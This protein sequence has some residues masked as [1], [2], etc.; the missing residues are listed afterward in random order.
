MKTQE[1]I[2]EFIVAYLHQVAGEEQTA[3]SLEWLKNPDNREIYMQME[4]IIRLSGEVRLLDNFNTYS[5]KN[6]VYRKFRASKMLV[7]T[8][9]VQRVAALLL[10][11]V[12]LGGIWLYVEKVQLQN[13]LAGGVIHQEIITQPGTKTHLFLPD[14][15]EVWLNSASK[16]RFPS[17]FTGDKR[18]IELDGEAYF[19]VFHNK[20]KPF[21]VKTVYLDVEALGTSFNLSAY[22]GDFKISTTLEEGKVRITNEKLP[23]KAYV[24]MPGSQLNFYPEKQ[25]YKSEEVIVNDVIAWKDGVLIFN[26]TPFSEVA[27]KLGRWFNA[28]IKITDPSIVNYRFTGT[29][30]SESLD[31]VLHLLTLSAPIDYLVSERK[32][33][34]NR[35]FSKQEIKI[36][37]NSTEKINLKK[38]K[39]VPMN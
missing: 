9:W 6:K 5:A 37:K 38:S 23:N 19:K 26:E 15:T 11:P 4:K 21:V 29:F 1:Q 24:L 14:S 34:E 2:P 3:L 13:S 36:W 25:D 20:E 35:S 33:L 17:I 7:I 31:Q 22:A 28:D 18:E 27:A 32:V 30:T 10:L 39:K 8:K 16:L 12:L